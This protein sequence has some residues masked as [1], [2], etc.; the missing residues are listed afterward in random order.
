M[1]NVRKTA[2]R[3]LLTAG[4]SLLA[5]CLFFVLLLYVIFSPSRDE[6]SKVASPSG[7]LVAKVVEINGGATTSFGYEVQVS[8][9]GFHLGGTEVASFY[10]AVRSD[11]AYGVN[12]RWVS[13]SELHVEYLTA[14]S[15]KLVARHIFGPPVRVVLQ[16]GI[17]DRTAPPGGMLYNLRHGHP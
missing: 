4:G 5:L 3:I 11:R 6:V 14:R 2:L 1:K 7:S 12:L 13:E 17:V 9:S 15:A 8:R 10:D 16:P